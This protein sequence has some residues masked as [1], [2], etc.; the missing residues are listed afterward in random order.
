MLKSNVGICKYC[1]APSSRIVIKDIQSMY[2][3]GLIFD[4]LECMN[5]GLKYTF[6]EPETSTLNAI[7]GQEYRYDLHRLFSY[8]KTYRA[9]KL[10]SS[11]PLTKSLNSNVNALELGAGN[12]EL[13]NVLNKEY[14]YKV[15]AVD[16]NIA[17]SN[18]LEVYGMSIEKFLGFNKIR[19]DLIFLSHTLEHLI[20]FD[21][22]FKQ[23]CAILK[24]GGRIILVVPNA[25]TRKEHWGYWA[26]PVHVYHF[27]EDFL[28]RLVDDNDLKVEVINFKSIDTLGFL[29]GVSS[30][31]RLKR[32][33]TPIKLVLFALKI[34]SSLFRLGYHFGD[35]DLIL[36]ARS[37]D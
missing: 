29:S 11:L 25:L 20:S 6:P 33:L 31:F 18:N 28:K 19:Y 3:D 16:S 4:I 30:K 26:I 5:C 23:I 21:T 32:N 2:S 34:F 7:Y 14:G 8:E 12:C 22:I 36:M 9:K 13:S 10:L 35:S 24:P 17:H 1:K 15:T 27:T 37:K